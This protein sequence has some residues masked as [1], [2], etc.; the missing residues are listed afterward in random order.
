MAGLAG[1]VWARAA[2][3]ATRSPAQLAQSR[4]HGAVTLSQQGSARAAHRFAA[5]PRSAEVACVGGSGGVRVQ[6]AC[7]VPVVSS[8]L[9]RGRSTQAAGDAASESPYFAW[10][11]SDHGGLKVSHSQY[12]SCTR[13]ERA[14]SVA[15]HSSTCRPPFPKTSTNRRTH[16]TV[17]HIF[18][19]MTPCAYVLVYVSQ[20][21]SARLTIISCLFQFFFCVFG[22]FVSSSFLFCPW[23]SSPM[24]VGLTDMLAL[25]CTMALRRENCH[26]RH[27]RQ[28]M[29]R[30]PRWLRFARAFSS[31]LR[32]TTRCCLPS[33]ILQWEER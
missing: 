24:F 29:T 12:V 22:C 25:N 4:L 6:H 9:A 3:C 10:H 30:L 19:P 31:T 5:L 1:P 16:T 8:V 17:P 2:R 27:H 13:F 33:R 15:T 21:I 14:A 28:Q 7:R 18:I 23:V 20:M 32:T 11:P 26:H